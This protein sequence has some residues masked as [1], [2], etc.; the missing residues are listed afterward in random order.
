VGDGPPGERLDRREE[1]PAQRREA[2]RDG[3]GER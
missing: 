2:G 3:E 1:E